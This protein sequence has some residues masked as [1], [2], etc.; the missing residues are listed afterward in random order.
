MRSPLLGYFARTGCVSSR[1]EKKRKRKPRDERERGLASASLNHHRIPTNTGNIFVAVC[2]AR[3]IQKRRALRRWAVVQLCART[4]RGFAYL[5]L[6]LLNVRWQYPPTVAA[7]KL[8]RRPAKRLAVILPEANDQVS[9]SRATQVDLVSANIPGDAPP[10]NRR[11]V[12]RS[13]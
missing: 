10:R 2:R 4:W 13:A 5:S 8:L 3:G 11:S 1:K 9:H 7:T 6:S 12:Y